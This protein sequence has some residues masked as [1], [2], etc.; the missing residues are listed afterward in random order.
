[1]TPF[2]QRLAEVQAALARWD[3]AAAQMALD[4]AA[5]ACV[6]ALRRGLPMLT[7]GNGGSAADAQHIAGELVGRFLR[8]RHALNVRALTADA[9]VLTAWANDVGF[10]DVFARQVEAYGAP[11]GVLLAL[12][13]SGR[14]AN[15]LA[16]AQRAAGLGMTVIAF[17]GAAGGP[18]T[19]LADVTIA[20]PSAATPRIQELHLVAYHFLCEAIEA[21]FC[22]DTVEV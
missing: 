12:S 5:A 7:C 13:T 21:A 17:V 11:G 6:A 20:A 8:T 19:A 18:L 15:V 4:A 9:S 2:P 3:G 10:D 1:M 14:S 16:A 22:A